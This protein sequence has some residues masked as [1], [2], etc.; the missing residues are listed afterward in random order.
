MEVASNV[1]MEVLQSSTTTNGLLG[2]FFYYF[3]LSIPIWICCCYACGCCCGGF[4][5]LYCITSDNTQS[6]QQQPVRY[7]EY[8][9]WV[10]VWIYRTR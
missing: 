3:V 10:E 9:E 5:L 4:G 1:T 7:V 6:V 8:W 2:L